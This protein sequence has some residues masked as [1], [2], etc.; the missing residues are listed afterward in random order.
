M[1]IPRSID[2][3]VMRRRLPRGPRLPLKAIRIILGL[4][5]SASPE[6]VQREYRKLLFLKGAAGSEKNPPAFDLAKAQ[7]VVE[8]E[9]GELSLGERLRCKIRY[10]SD[11]VILGSRAFVEF[12]CQ[13]LKEKLG[14]KRKSGP[15]RL[16]DPGSSERSGSFANCESGRSVNLKDAPNGHLTPQLT[17]KATARRV[18]TEASDL[19]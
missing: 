8:Q 11:G 7:E 12:H 16:K 6:E 15:I 4:P 19:H 17:N 10:F 5:E 13:R 18:P 1:R 9:K 14:Y 2:T 3:A